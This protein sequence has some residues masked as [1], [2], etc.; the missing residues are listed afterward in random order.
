MF[1][2]KI[3]KCLYVRKKVKG[4]FHDFN[5]VEDFSFSTVFSMSRS[6]K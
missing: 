4:V 3:F 6:L 5:W 1:T 2:E